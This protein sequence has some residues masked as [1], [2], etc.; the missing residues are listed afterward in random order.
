VRAEADAEDRVVVQEDGAGVEVE[1]HA[2]AQR[3]RCGPAQGEYGVALRRGVREADADQS[4]KPTCAV[5]LPF[6][7]QLHVVAAVGNPVAASQCKVLAPGEGAAEDTLPAAAQS[8][9]QGQAGVQ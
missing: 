7:E 5:G 1:A 3:G 8:I 4:G 2:V 9:M 6:G